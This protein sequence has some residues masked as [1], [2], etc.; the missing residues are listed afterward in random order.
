MGQSLDELRARYPGA[1]AYRFGASPE[2][3]AALLALVRAGR[4]RATCLAEAEVEAGEAPPVVGRCDIAVDFEGVPQLV[5][6]TLELRRV[7]FC[8]M[9][10]EMALVE[11]EDEDLAGWREG[12]E[13]YYRRAGIFH[14]EMGL[15]WER[16]ELVEDLA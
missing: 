9:T 11:G 6:R 16:F 10:E 14:P 4:K 15:I 7:R 5:T 3:S 2:G 1:V 13:R 12:H 8:D